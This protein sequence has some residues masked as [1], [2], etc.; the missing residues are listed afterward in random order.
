[1]F[2]NHK[3]IQAALNF[4]YVID[5]MSLKDFFFIDFVVAQGNL[6]Y[7]GCTGVFSKGE[8][9]LESSFVFA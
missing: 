5:G 7:V 6:D 9:K 3:V 2:A 8:K 4:F 1:V